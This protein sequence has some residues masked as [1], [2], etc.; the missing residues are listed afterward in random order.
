ALDALDHRA[1]VW[2]LAAITYECVT[3]KIPFNGPT[4]PAILLSILTDEPKP[5]SEVGKAH[6]VPVTLDAVIEEALLKDMNIRIPTV[7]RLVDRIGQAYGLE[8][9]HEQWAT[10]PQAELKAQI[11]AG[12]P[13]R[14][15][16]HEDMLATVPNLKA[17]DAAFRVADPFKAGSAGG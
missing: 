17:M 5:V 11:A 13:K 15:A 1:D 9:S 10:A 16:A 4:G 7:A 12:L 14:L 3:G 8:G 2:S 6:R